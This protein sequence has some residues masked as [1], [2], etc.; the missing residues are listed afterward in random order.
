MQ[1]F[2]I[3]QKCAQVFVKLNQMI[4]KL[5]HI[6]PAKYAI[7]TGGAVAS[8]LQGE[9]PKDYDI[10]FNNPTTLKIV[11][12]YYAKVVKEL[13]GVDIKVLAKQTKNTTEFKF[14]VQ[15]MLSFKSD[16]KLGIR[17][18]TQNAISFT[19]GI[20][21]IT[22][23][24]GGPEGIHST[25]DFEHLTNYYTVGGLH[26]SPTTMLLAQDKVLV[27]RSSLYPLSAMLRVKKFL[28]RGYTI[29]RQQLSL[30][31]LDLMMLGIKLGKMSPQDMLTEVMNQ[32]KGV[33][34]SGAALA[35]ESAET[36]QYQKMTHENA[37]AYVK[38][39]LK[40]ST[41]YETTD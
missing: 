12:T 18:I 24:Y 16:N 31:G 36:Q 34:V 23:F 15:E 32:F 22:R 26:L 13:L 14:D 20:Q 28:A 9:T 19:N 29:N 38:N 5:V 37:L 8:M 35:V 6:N 30:I 41:K 17:T 39:V 1:K 33:Y 27:Y 21:I 10:F 40:I 2:Q 3:Q 4:P 25:F 7:L 11:M